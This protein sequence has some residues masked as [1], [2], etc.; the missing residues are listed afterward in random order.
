MKNLRQERSSTS[1]GQSASQTR[2][3]GSQ[4]VLGLLVLGVVG[5]DAALTMQMIRSSSFHHPLLLV[6][7]VVPPL[8][9]ILIYMMNRAAL[10]PFKKNRRPRYLRVIRPTSSTT[11]RGSSKPLFGDETT[12]EQSQ[13]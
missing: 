2:R 1:K 10:K 9:L 13:S 5:F 4:V 3:W 12:V 8:T 7:G 6:L 11:A